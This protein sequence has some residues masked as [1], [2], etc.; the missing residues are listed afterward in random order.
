MSDGKGQDRFRDLAML[1][2]KHSVAHRPKIGACAKSNREKKEP[3]ILG[4]PDVSMSFHT[5]GI[6]VQ[7]G[8]DST[9]AD[10]WIDG[11]KTMGQNTWGGT[12]A[13]SENTALVQRRCL[14]CGTERRL[15]KARFSESTTGRPTTWA[16][17]GQERSCFG[18]RYY[19]KVKGCTRIFGRQQQDRWM[20]R[21][22]CCH[23]RCGPGTSE[24]QSVNCSAADDLYGHGSGS[25]GSQFV[26]R[27]SGFDT[28]AKIVW[29]T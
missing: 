22:W 28:W 27:N 4:P 14:S 10:M 7:M 17:K 18:R 3:R 12:W 6:T 8:G 25:C 20:E 26:D 5:E 29:K 13:H 23:R 19:R 21:M 15:C 11:H 1:S 2:V 24:S 16:R 9:V